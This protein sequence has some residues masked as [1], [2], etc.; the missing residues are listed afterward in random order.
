M[1]R[2]R[3]S[4]SLLS[5]SEAVPSSKVSASVLSASVVIGSSD[6]RRCRG[7]GDEARDRKEGGGEEG[8][9]CESWC[10]SGVSGVSSWSF[11]EICCESV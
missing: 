3:A 1:R 8:M 7:E 6:E 10:P 11:S 2:C 9:V 5:L 4:P